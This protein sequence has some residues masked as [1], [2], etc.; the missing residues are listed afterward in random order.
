MKVPPF[1]YSLTLIFALMVSGFSCSTKSDLKKEKNDFYQLAYRAKNSMSKPQYKRWLQNQQ[2]ILQD[3]L[4]AMK[5]VEEREGRML[6]QHEVMTESSTTVGG[7]QDIHGFKAER[8]RQSLKQ[9]NE[10]KIM[11]ERK[12]FYINSQLSELDSKLKY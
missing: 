7:P 1:F 12:L 11:I 8:S 2:R 3:Q 9:M 10:R 5:G 6:N 4:S